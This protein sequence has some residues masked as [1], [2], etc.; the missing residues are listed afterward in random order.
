MKLTRIKSLPAI[1]GVELEADEVDGNVKRLVIKANGM[2][3]LV[4]EH[5]GYAASFSLYAP[6]KV[7]RFRVTGG[8]IVNGREGQL[9]QVFDDERTANE[10][11]EGLTE[12][13]VESV[14]TAG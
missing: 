1:P 3:V 12:G 2:P 5:E 10:I 7:T 14:E 9:D 6:T 4:I 8:V 11:A 13:K